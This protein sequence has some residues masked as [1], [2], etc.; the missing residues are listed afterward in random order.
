MLNMKKYILLIILLVSSFSIYTEEV[1][2]NPPQEKTQKDNE[3]GYHEHDGFY[4]RYLMNPFIGYGFVHSTQ[5]VNYVDK[6]GA[7]WTFSLQIGYS[8][9]QNIILFTSLD[10]VA[11]PSPFNPFDLLPKSINPSA[12]RGATSSDSSGNFKYSIGANYYLMPQNMYVSLSFSLAHI[13]FSREKVFFSSAD[14]GFGFATSL[15]KEWWVSKN[16]GLGLALNLSY[17]YFPTTRSG[18]PIITPIHAFAIGLSFSATY[19]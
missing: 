9:N 2:N 13:G 8:F 5:N 12:Q 15:G 11:V 18:Y 17:D 3:Q 1:P 16:W 10:S 19:N 14:N 7:I 6:S 4:F